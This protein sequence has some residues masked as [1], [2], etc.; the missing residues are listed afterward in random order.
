MNVIIFGEEPVAECLCFGE[1]IEVAGEVVHVS[2]AA[3]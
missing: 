2:G 1:E 3:A